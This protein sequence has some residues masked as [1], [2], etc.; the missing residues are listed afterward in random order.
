[1]YKNF[2]HS[3]NI[4][5]YIGLIF[6][7][8]KDLFLLGLFVAC[9]VNAMCD[10]CCKNNKTKEKLKEVEKSLDQI[11][12]LHAK[13]KEMLKKNNSNDI[14]FDNFQKNIL[15]DCK[16]IDIEADASN[17][18]LLGRYYEASFNNFVNTAILKNSDASKDRKKYFIFLPDKNF[19][20]SIEKRAEI[21]KSLDSIFN[22]KSHNLKKEIA[23]FIYNNLFIGMF[24]AKPDIKKLV[25]E[26]GLIFFKVEKNNKDNC[27]YFI[28]LLGN[29]KFF[30]DENGEFIPY[31]IEL[32]ESSGFINVDVSGYFEKK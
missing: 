15:E 23:T 7:V 10:F 6:M 31:I 12:I 4:Y 26:Y 21:S 32:T 9:E 2:V 3:A 25:S 11:D 5:I 8:Y 24:K 28:V 17:V 16:K 27:Y 22:K 29:K 13:A 20:E 14:L 18:E 19:V 1:M 30:V